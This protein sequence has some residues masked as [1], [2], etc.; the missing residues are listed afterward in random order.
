MCL[1][2]TPFPFAFAG[3]KSPFVL[4]SGFLSGFNRWYT[5][6]YDQVE[7]EKGILRGKGKIKTESGSVY[8]FEDTVSPRE[9]DGSFLFQRKVKVEKATDDQGFF[10]RVSFVM[11]THTEPGISISSARGHG[12]SRIKK[13]P[14]FLW[15]A[16]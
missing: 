3:Q 14:D 1:G 7:E 16:T 15:D 13:R 5:A 11:Q 8:A 2:R 9:N 10:S 12:I 4:P 6:P